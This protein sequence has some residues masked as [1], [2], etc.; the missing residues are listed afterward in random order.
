MCVVFTY[1]AA[2]FLFLPT[3]C[4]QTVFNVAS[5]KNLSDKKF[6]ESYTSFLTLLDAK[7]GADIEIGAPV[8]DSGILVA[9]LGPG[10]IIGSELS[11]FNRPGYRNARF[12]SQ[13]TYVADG[14]VDFLVLP[15]SMIINVNNQ[16]TLKLKL[17][18][19]STPF[20]IHSG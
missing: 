7:L 13:F 9:Q 10:S 18:A 20:N 16:V 5:V 4:I 1:V 11:R 8:S 19:V 2:F 12:P 6:I 17:P 15:K 14:F 3:I